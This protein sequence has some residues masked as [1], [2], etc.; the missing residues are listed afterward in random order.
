MLRRT[1]LFLI[2]ITS[3]FAQQRPTARELV[4]HIQQQAGITPPPGT[5]DTFKAGDPDQPVTGVV[6]TMMATFDV[7]E[8]AA[9]SG[10]NLV[11]THEPTF[12]NHQDDTAALGALNDPVLAQ[13]QQFI[14]DHHLIIWRFHDGW[15]ARKPDGIL[16][17]VRNALGWQSFQD[18][19]EPHLFKLTETT[20]EA[21]AAEMKGRLHA[22]VVRMVG[23]RQMKVTRIAL[24]PGAAGSLEQMKVLERNDVQ[25]LV[26]GE[27]REWETVEYVGDAATEHR[28]KALIIL[29]HVSSEQAGMEECTRWL[30]TFLPDISVTFIPAQDPF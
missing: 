8:R 21:L 14:R 29:G 28:D 24:M 15:H 4:R 17:G 22:H 25:V 3:A 7:L 20:V 12:Y 2:C 13:K 23:D 9:A 6:V 27:T 30:K 19:T 10:A 18:A 5:V 26:V 11:I 16:E 1:A